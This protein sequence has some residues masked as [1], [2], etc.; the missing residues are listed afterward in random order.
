ML[1]TRLALCIDKSCVVLTR[2]SVGQ[3]DD[4]YTRDQTNRSLL[5]RDRMSN[6]TNLFRPE[7]NHT[8]RSALA[9]AD[10]SRHGGRRGESLSGTAIYC[11]LITNALLLFCDF[12]SPDLKYNKFCHTG[13]T[14]KSE[15]SVIFVSAKACNKTVCICFSFC[16]VSD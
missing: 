2:P 8:H 14:Y 1:Y 9:A 11:A 5:F 3:P 12:S 16:A 15:M 13:L 4:D 6:C 10:H 7:R